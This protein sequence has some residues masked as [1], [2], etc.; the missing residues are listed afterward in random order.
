MGTFDL[1]SGL[2][3]EQAVRS[4]SWAASKAM[5]PNS[6]QYR[7]TDSSVKISCKDIFPYSGSMSVRGVG[8]GLKGKSVQRGSRVECTYIS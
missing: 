1:S 5:V 4:V 2:L 6:S 8:I 3:S 7:T